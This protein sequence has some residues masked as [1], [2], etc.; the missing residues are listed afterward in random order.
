[1][2]ELKVI[3]EGTGSAGKCGAVD[4]LGVVGRYLDPLMVLM[5]QQWEWSV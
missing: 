5:T 1:M 4:V 3:D 2:G